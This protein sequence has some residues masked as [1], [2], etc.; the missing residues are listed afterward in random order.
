[1][2][3]TM[4]AIA[5]DYGYVHVFERQINGLGQPGDVF[6]AI[7]TSGRSANMIKAVEAA[8]QKGMRVLALNGK[9]GGTLSGDP[10]S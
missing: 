10:A 4:T 2:L 9:D 7:T 5:N 8:H 3:N 1:M 6:L